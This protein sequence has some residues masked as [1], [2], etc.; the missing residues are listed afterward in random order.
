[1]K[2]K[3]KL[4]ILTIIISVCIIATATGVTVAY[5]VGAEGTNQI[6]PQTDST[7][8]NYYAKYFIYEEVKN[9][10]NAVV[11]YRIVGFKDT[12]LENV[13]IPRYATGG[14][15]RTTDANGK[16]ILKEIKVEENETAQAVLVV[17]NT[18]FA[19][20]TDKRI[21]VTL[22]I[23]TTVSIEAGAFMGLTSL[24]KITIKLVSELTST[25]PQYDMYIGAN[26]FFGCFNVK[27]FVAPKQVNL[28]VNG[29]VYS[30]GNFEEFKNATGLIVD[31]LTRS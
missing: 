7:D 24:T 8:W 28:R 3:T 1:M 18:I 27:T 20:D 14:W 16:V 12:V 15:L 22:T 21:P 13:I 11:G 19:G 9:G 17:G 2:A 6:A 30:E 31:G 5:W 23:P 4:T 10:S 26:A 29:I 25:E